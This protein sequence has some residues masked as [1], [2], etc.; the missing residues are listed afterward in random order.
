MKPNSFKATHIFLT[1]AVACSSL[2]FGCATG[3]VLKWTGQSECVGT[4]GAVQT[5][6]GIDFYVSGDPNGRYKILSI[7]T[8]SYYNGGNL[9]LTAMSQQTAISDVVKEAKKEGADAVII[10]SSSYSTFGT[11]TSGSATIN[12]DTA[13]YSS[14]T[15]VNGAQ[16]VAMKLVKY[17][18]V[19]R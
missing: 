6:D 14:H 11:S 4:G 18:D 16:N 3:T 12:S 1:I 10:T 17:I 9:M 19:K 2:L 5:V 7:V 15:T 8:G 13:Y